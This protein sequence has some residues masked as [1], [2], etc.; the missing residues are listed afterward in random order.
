MDPKRERRAARPGPVRRPDGAR[1]GDGADRARRG[2]ALGGGRR[3]PFVDL[4]PRSEGRLERRDARQGRP[5]SRRPGSA[6]STRTSPPSTRPRSGVLKGC[7]AIADGDRAMRAFSAA[8]K[9]VDEL[10]DEHGDGI[11]GKDALGAAGPERR[12]RARRGARR[13]GREASAEVGDR[14]V[15]G[16]TRRET[17]GRRSRTAR[18]AYK[19]QVYDAFDAFGKDVGA[20]V[21]DDRTLVVLL[22]HA[23]SVAARPRLARAVRAPPP[24]D[25]L[26]RR[27]GLRPLGPPHE[28]RVRPEGPRPQAATRASPTPSRSCTWSAARRTRDPRPGQMAEI[29][30][31]TGQGATEDLRRLKNGELQWLARASADDAEGDGEPPGPSGAA[32]GS[33]AGAQAPRRSRAVR[34]ARGAQG[35]RA[36]HRPEPP[37]AR[38]SG[39]SRTRRG[40]SCRPTLAG[41]GAAPGAPRPDVPAAKRLLADGGVGRAATFPWV[42]LHY[43]DR[44]DAGLDDLADALATAV[45][46]GAG[47]RDG[48]ADRRARA[49]RRGCWPPARTRWRSARSRDRRP[50]RPPG[51]SPSRAGHPESGLGW[52][53]A[54]FEALL[55]AALDVDGLLAAGGRR[56]RARC[57][58]RPPSG[59]ASTPPGAA[60]RG[61]K[62]ALRRALLA[63]GR[64][65]CS[66]TRASSSRSSG[67]PRRRSRRRS[68]GRV[69][70]PRG[71]IPTFVGSLR[72]ATRA[73]GDRPRGGW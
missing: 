39:R 12:P 7:A 5:T 46:E 38:R 19:S 10:L 2:R 41:P 31:Y 45:G 43:E 18:R 72:S 29:Y 26:G 58:R 56:R 53:D 9:G 60:A 67:R 48:A 32:R 61:E 64:G 25:R 1:S 36:R 47:R 59:R 8:S 69:R 70:K 27:P 20:R 66:S 57:P 33:A 51:S 16:R 35:V 50:I 4:P 21:V 23:L 55:A 62:D 22:E 13:R 30:C 52:D 14:Q 6:P 73:R 68:G 40:G 28:R 34:Q 44:S 54:D 3:R 63:G 37:P 42:E 17:V 15:P 71:A 49:W 65:P 11:P 24:E